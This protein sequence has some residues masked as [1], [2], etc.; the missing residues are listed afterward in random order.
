MS[1]DALLLGEERWVVVIAANWRL[2]TS[3]S[4]TVDSIIVRLGALNLRGREAGRRITAEVSDETRGL[5]FLC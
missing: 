5:I 3:A 4:G 2:N 1:R